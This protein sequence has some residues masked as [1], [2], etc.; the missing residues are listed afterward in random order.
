MAILVY[1]LLLLLCGAGYVIYNLNKKYTE[2]EEI[3]L[4]NQEFVLSLR[5]RVQSHRSVLKQLDRIG[6][7]EAD[8]ETGYF[9]KEL[10]KIIN[11]INYYFDEKP[12][13]EDEETGSR[14]VGM[15]SNIE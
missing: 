8:D 1:I 4:E 14:R 6:S 12:I 2:L 5:N 9:F 13:E 15:F 3:A 11:D 10:K 7:F